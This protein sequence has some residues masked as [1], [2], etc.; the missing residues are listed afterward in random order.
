MTYGL[1]KFKPQETEEKPILENDSE[2]ESFEIREENFEID[3]DES[4]PTNS[5]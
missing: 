3:D 2:E 4:Q 1:M 5:L